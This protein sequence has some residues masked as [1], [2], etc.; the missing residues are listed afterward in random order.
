MRAILLFVIFVAVQLLAEPVGQIL[1]G[2][3]VGGATKPSA[4]A[5]GEALLICEG[6]LCVILWLWFRYGPR[7]HKSS[8]VSLPRK[9]FRGL[10]ARQGFSIL[11]GV[12]LGFGLSLL[13]VPL[14][15]P[16]G[17]AE[18]LF[19]AMKNSWPCLALLCLVGPLCEELVFRAG[20]VRSLRDN[21]LPGWAAAALSAA[22]FA[23]VHG[24]LAQGI[25]AFL[26]GWVLGLL[27]LR[28]RSLALCLPAH[29]AN[30]VFAVTVLYY[31]YLGHFADTWPIAA[32]LALGALHLGLGVLNTW[33]ALR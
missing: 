31:P 30:N 28:S 23:L 16:D 11:A 25:P 14:N 13:L 6:A 32:T 15:L 4:V 9:G 29:I 7:K 12:L 5:T 19:D 8:A 27:Y 20:I 24:N 2:V 26:I 1:C 10:Y 3:P 18:K 22:A 21:G 17:G 33:R